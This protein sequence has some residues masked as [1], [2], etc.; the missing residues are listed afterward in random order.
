MR[1]HLLEQG[2]VDAVTG[3]VEKADVARGMAQV[4]QKLIAL[5]RRAFEE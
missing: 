4:F 1:L 5:L 2:A 3:E